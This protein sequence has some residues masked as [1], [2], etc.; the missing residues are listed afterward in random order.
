VKVVRRRLK[1]ELSVGLVRQLAR[2]NKRVAAIKT[3][4]F[5]VFL[6]VQRT[7]NNFYYTFY[8]KKGRVLATIS[9]GMTGFEGNQKVSVLSGE[10]AG[11]MIL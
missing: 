11:K 1:N 10:V 4:F 9:A 6:T 2:S 8:T 3:K 7:I 5:C